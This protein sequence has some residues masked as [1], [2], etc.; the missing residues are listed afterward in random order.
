MRFAHY[1]SRRLNTAHI[2]RTRTNGRG[3]GVAHGRRRAAG[4]GRG[5]WGRE[6]GL[7]SPI[8][9]WQ[10]RGRETERLLSKGRTEI[11]GS[12]KNERRGNA[13]AGEIYFTSQSV[14]KGTGLTDCTLLLVFPTLPLSPPRR[15]PCLIRSESVESM[16]V[17]GVEA[18][19]RA[20]QM[21]GVQ[22]ARRRRARIAKSRATLATME[23][24]NV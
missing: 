11:L 9:P 16:R 19:E 24:R 17:I 10:Q 5:G 2:T 20:E 8:E 15:P 23:S 22:T 12:R 4:G 3:A 21:P 6:R 1:H 13:P 7:F 14:H 18:R